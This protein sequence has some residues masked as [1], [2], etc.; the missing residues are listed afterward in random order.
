MLDGVSKSFGATAAVSNLNLSVQRGCICGL[1]GPNGAGKTTTIRMIMDII[2]PDHGRIDVLGCASPAAAKD[3]LG[4]LPEE[5]GLYRKMKVLQTLKY[6]AAIKGVPDRQL[7]GRARQWLELM[8]ASSWANRRIEELS[9][10]MQQKIQFAVACINEPELL[11]LDEPLAALDPINLD[12]LKSIILSFRSRGTAILLSTHMMHEAE[13][14]C[15]H[16]VL[17]NKGRSV[18][19]GTLSEVRGRRQADTVVA[20]LEGDSAFLDALPFVAAVRRD[21][22]AVE[23]SLRD[24]ADSQQLLA[25]MVPR[26]RVISFRLKM[27]T[28]HE[29]FVRTVGGSDAQGS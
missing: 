5:R 4:Y 14:L 12:S 6:F 27:P 18:L 21:G 1:L 20:E 29:I 16:I 15:D 10:G 24:G 23:M 2:V 25:A 28:L 3:R 26:V 8:G 9:K 19:Q 13:E 17:V 22:Q 7:D 11:I